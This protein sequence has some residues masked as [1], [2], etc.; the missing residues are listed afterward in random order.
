MEKE[1]TVVEILKSTFFFKNLTETQIKGFDKSFSKEYLQMGDQ[2]FIEDSSLEEIRIL[3][4]GEV[5]EVVEHPN[6]KKTLTLNIEQP[7]SLIGL[8]LYKAQN[9]FVYISAATDCFFFKG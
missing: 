2:I 4:N 6:T 3:V 7:I 8:N 5:R 1:L 9:H